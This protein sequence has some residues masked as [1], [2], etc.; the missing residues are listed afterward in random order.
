MTDAKEYPEFAHKKTIK[1]FLQPMIEQVFGG[2]GGRDVPERCA[3]FF[4]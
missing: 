3:A 4:A 1:Q 2:R